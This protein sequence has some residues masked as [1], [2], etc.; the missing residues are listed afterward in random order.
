MISVTTMGLL[1]HYHPKVQQILVY[2]I[3]IVLCVVYFKGSM[4]SKVLNQVLYK[5]RWYL[6]RK[7]KPSAL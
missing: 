5:Q 4:N 1:F 6:I 2:F 3:D 7:S